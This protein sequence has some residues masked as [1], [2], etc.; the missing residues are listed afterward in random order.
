MKRAITGGGEGVVSVIFLSMSYKFDDDERGGGPD[1]GDAD[2]FDEMDDVIDCPKCGAEIYAYSEK[3]P[4][5]GVWLAMR[6]R[7][8]KGIGKGGRGRMFS[9]WL[10]AVV[11]V[12]CV[13]LILLLILR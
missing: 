5:C 13:L 7:S 4:K 2:L 11:A 12:V 8:V 6:E 1:E 10:L 3:C 9:R